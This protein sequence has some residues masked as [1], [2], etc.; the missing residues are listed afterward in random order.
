MLG[1]LGYRRVSDSEGF[2]GYGIEDGKD[3]LALVET[4]NPGTARPGF[5]VAIAADS[6]GAVDDF[7]NA[8]IRHGA[9]DNG[10]P[11]LRPQ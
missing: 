10:A 7:H 9:A 8:A 1:A 2:A 11:G 3:K 4:E 5:H 6:P